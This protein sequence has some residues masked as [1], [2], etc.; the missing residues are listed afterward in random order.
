MRVIPPDLAARLADTRGLATAQ[1]ASGSYSL[2]QRALELA[3]GAL[4]PRQIEIA[5]LHLEG[6][7]QTGIAER[8]GIT[9]AAV[10]QALFGSMRRGTRV[11]G[12]VKRLQKA[13]E[14]EGRGDEAESE[15]PPR[16]AEWFRP[17][18]SPPS[19]SLF[20]A[21]AVLIVL[22]ELSDARGRVAY[23]S[24]L[25]KLPRAVLD[26]SLPILRYGGWISTDGISIQ[27]LKT[28]AGTVAE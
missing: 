26:G 5:A 10:S 4:T 15:D 28:P 19:P 21:L 23:G 6:V 7:S 3:A 9:Q 24:A 14:A 20:V 2:R 8:L 18:I 17:A 12:I 1:A 27:V 13:V 25:E 22:R 16:Y 11:G